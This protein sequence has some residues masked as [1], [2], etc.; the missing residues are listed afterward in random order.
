MSASRKASARNGSAEAPRELDRDSA[1]SS[2]PEAKAGRH[3]LH[4]GRNLRHARM[5]NGLTLRDL[6][7][8]VGCS[9]SLLSKIENDK[10]IPSLQMLHKIVSQLDTSIGLLFSEPQDEQRIVMRQGDRQALST[11]YPERLGSGKG[12]R[13]EWLVPYPEARLLS[14]SI[15]IIAPGGGSQGTISHKGEEVGYVL[16]GKFE[17]SVSDKVFMLEPGD[18]FFFPSETP[19]GYRNPGKLETRVLW[20]NTPPTF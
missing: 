1:D 4:I 15:H 12:V 6:S 13:L 14:G 17:L 2:G 18:S 8:R 5:V 10:T 3:F 9:E 20:I 7:E 16:Q 11:S 19:H